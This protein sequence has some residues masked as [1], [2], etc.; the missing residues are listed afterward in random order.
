MVDPGGETLQGELQQHTLACGMMQH[1]LSCALPRVTI[2][3]GQN[4]G[5]ERAGSALFKEGW[6]PLE[7]KD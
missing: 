7:N 6:M 4:A 2:S 5:E 3:R 1:L